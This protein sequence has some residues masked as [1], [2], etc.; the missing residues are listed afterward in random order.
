L[1]ARKL[2]NSEQVI[3]N[4]EAAMSLMGSQ[5]S[6]LLKLKGENA[7]LRAQLNSLSAPVEIDIASAKKFGL[8][9]KGDGD[10]TVIEGVGPKINQLIHDGGIGTFSE[11][12]QTEVASVQRILDAAG[13]R[14]KLARPDTWPKQAGLAANNAWSELKKLQDE[15][16]GGV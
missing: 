2:R 9:L 7:D 10:F 1:L 5:D 8:K 13:P 14:Y 4:D 12:S 11:L 6:E 16:D 3:S 15:L